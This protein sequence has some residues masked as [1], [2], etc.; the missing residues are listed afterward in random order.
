M[1]E[2]ASTRL[3]HVQPRVANTTRGHF[4]REEA[5]IGYLFLAPVALILVG[6][7]GYP[8]VSS[9]VLSVQDKVIGRDV[10]QFVGLANYTAL[11]N[12]A[13]Y[14]QALANTLVFTVGS[15]S[16]KLVLGLLTALALNQPL[17][18]RTAMR[19]IVL[20]P[21]ALP[22]VV[23]LVIW[24]WMFND[25]LGVFNFVLLRLG[26]IQEPHNWLG[27]PATAMPAVVLVNIW[28]GF[29]FFALILLA[30][31][32]TIPAELYEAAR[33]DGAG[34]W[35]RFRYITVPGILTVLMIVTLLSTI[36]TVND[37]AV[38]WVLTKGGPGHATA[39]LST[40]TFERAFFNREISRGVAVSVTL[41]PVLVALII[42]LVRSVARREQET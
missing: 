26:A 6:L 14:H 18:G 12:D 40:Y 2:L 21:W 38:V 36:W 29:P 28:R 23:T 41:L 19:G 32:Q 9:L 10:V 22:T 4:L 33:V 16:I 39:L 31:L 35:A 3:E 25:L 17:P 5:A 8:L 7:L 24:G 15:I 30:G 1:K 11:F 34:R 42:L 27:D 37:F 13:V 20:L